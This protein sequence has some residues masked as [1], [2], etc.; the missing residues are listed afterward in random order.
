MIRGPRRALL[1]TAALLAGAPLASWLPG[2]AAAQAPSLPDL[3]ASAKR[4]VVAV[5]TLSKLRNPSFRFLGTGFAFGDGSRIGTCA[6]LLLPLDTASNETL[7]IA[8]PA[9]AASN[10]AAVLEAKPVAIDRDADVAVLQ[11][12]GAPL[13]GL[14]LD[15][16]EDAREGTDVVLIGFPI[17]ALLGLFPAVHRGVVAAITP[18]VTPGANSASL[19]AQNVQIMRG[20]PVRLLQLDATA[21]PG[22]SGSPLIDAATGRVVG[23]VSMGLTKGNRESALSAPT[24]ISYAVPVRYLNALLA[25]R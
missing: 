4:S 12:G 17:G 24:G 23:V 21:Y 7:A 14:P 18:H 9:P 16:G 19:R 1:R 5:G 20:K 10:V 13:P 22:S 8:V 25:G 15:D 2:R 3:A 11:H 6:H